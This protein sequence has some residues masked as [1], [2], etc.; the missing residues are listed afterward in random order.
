MNAF[1]EFQP[2]HRPA[3]VHILCICTPSCCLEISKGF[4]YTAHFTLF[5]LPRWQITLSHRINHL[6]SQIILQRDVGKDAAWTGSPDPLPHSWAL[7]LCCF[8][9]V[10]SALAMATCCAKYNGRIIHGLWSPVVTGW[11]IDLIAAFKSC[12]HMGFTAKAR[13][14]HKKNTAGGARGRLRGGGG[15]RTWHWG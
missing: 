12:K 6:A 3:A 9:R 10:D 13:S 7:V 8:E 15:S 4:A 2:E 1:S 5:P 14:S 11:R